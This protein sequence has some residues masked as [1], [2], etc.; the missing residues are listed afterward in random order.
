MSTKIN[1]SEP[2]LDIKITWNSEVAET[3]SHQ[4]ASDPP[5]FFMIKVYQV[6]KDIVQIVCYIRPE[7]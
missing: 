5:E 7:L 4:G 1:A 2:A 3:D 6:L